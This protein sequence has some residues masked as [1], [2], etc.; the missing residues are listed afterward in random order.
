MTTK[1]RATRE[2]WPLVLL[3]LLPLAVLSACRGPAVTYHT[4][5][6]TG[7]PKNWAAPPCAASLGVGPLSLPD[8]LSHRGVIIRTDD[9]TVEV[10]PTHEWGGRLGDELLRTLTANLRLRLPG[11]DVQALPWEAAQAP[12]LQV[13]VSL[14]RFDGALGGAAVLRG[15]WVVQDP[16]SGRALT[17]GAATLRRAARGKGTRALVEAQSRLVADLADKIVAALGETC[18]GSGAGLVPSPSTQRRT[19]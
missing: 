10:S 2:A 19:P 17:R 6:V 5:G 16:Q 8:L 13:V 4:L 14:E 18:R 1:K 7:P 9:F 3:L 12:R 15:T 11:A